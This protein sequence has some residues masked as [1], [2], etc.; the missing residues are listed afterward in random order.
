MYGDKPIDENSEWLA[1]VGYNYPPAGTVYILPGA[2]ANKRYAL[3][4]NML[5]A[6]K[7]AMAKHEE[8]GKPVFSGISIKDDTLTFNAYTYDPATGIA[9]EYDSVTVTKTVFAGADPGFKP[10]PTDLLSTLPQQIWSFCSV[11]FA[12]LFGD[13]LFRLLPGMI[14][15]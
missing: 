6:V 9:A 5:P 15:G 7:N 12:T 2:A 4:P 11:V 1:Y 3:H 8:P 13:Y 14:G 10:L